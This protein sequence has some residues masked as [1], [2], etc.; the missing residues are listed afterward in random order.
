MNN[1]ELYHYGVLGMKWGVRRKRSMSDDAK[2]T[3]SIKKKKIHEMSNNEL[4]EANNRLQLESQY[5]QLTK[6]KSIGKKALQA[7]IGTASTITAVTAAAATYKKLGS[8][9]GTKALDAIGDWIVKDI[10]F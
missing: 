1:Y 9:Y 4:R 10:K 6:R 8:K 3:A 2:K 5:K 7:F